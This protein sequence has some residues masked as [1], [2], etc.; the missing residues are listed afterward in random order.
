[1]PEGW[2][3]VIVHFPDDWIPALEAT[4]KKAGGISKLIRDAV[5]E[6]LGKRKLSEPRLPGRPKKDETAES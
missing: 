4:G 2:K 5:R 1:M 6:K 3:Q